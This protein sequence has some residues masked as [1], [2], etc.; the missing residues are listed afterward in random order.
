MTA[1]D[2][3]PGEE[4]MVSYG[5]GY[6]RMLGI[7]EEYLYSVVRPELIY[8]LKNGCTYFELSAPD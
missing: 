3:Y 5:K 4:L 1:R 6:M 8:S 7:W 2:I